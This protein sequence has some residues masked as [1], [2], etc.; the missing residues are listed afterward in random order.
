MAERCD[1]SNWVTGMRSGSCWVFQTPTSWPCGPRTALHL[2]PILAP[3]TP[4]HAPILV[5]A[6][7]RHMPSAFP[8]RLLL[9]SGWGCVAVFVVYAVLLQATPSIQPSGPGS[10]PSSPHPESHATGAKSSARPVAPQPSGPPEGFP[11]GGGGPGPRSNATHCAFAHPDPAGPA[12]G[13]VVVVGDNAAWRTAMR[14]EKVVAAYRL[15]WEHHPLHMMRLTQGRGAYTPAFF[16][17]PNGTHA[18]ALVV[19]WADPGSAPRALHAAVQALG[20]HCVADDPGLLP[21]QLYLMFGAR[22]PALATLAAAEGWPQTRA[23]LVHSAPTVGFGGQWD[24]LQDVFL[25][26]TLLRLPHVVL[27]NHEELNMDAS[28]PDVDVLVANY[29]QACP[30]MTG[31]PEACTPPETSRSMLRRFRA[32]GKM[33]ALDY[34]YIG[35]GYYALQWQCA[36]LQTRVRPEGEGRMYNILSPVH[37]FHTLLYHALLHKPKVA[38]EYKQRLQALGSA[39][40]VATQGWGTADLLQLLDRFMVDNGYPYTQPKNKFVQYQSARVAKLLQSRGKPPG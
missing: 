22:A 25:A 8:K 9:L 38:P 36:M 13:L 10:G 21:G 16:A 30:V 11:I 5:P 39:A 33:T 2:S 1:E 40:Q 28:H 35:D 12:L 31:R 18:Y 23:P 27:R 20:A 32:G 24:S 15:D 6:W 17:P 19:S 3:H 29:T 14:L 4:L 26:A 37:Y 34:T 7:R